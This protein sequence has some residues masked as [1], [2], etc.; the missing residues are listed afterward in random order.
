MP[1]RT[2]LVR[3][4]VIVASSLLPLAFPAS[5]SLADG[6]CVGNRRVVGYYPSWGVYARNYHPADIPA[7]KV[8][9]INYAFAV[10]GPDLL[11]TFGDRF[12][13]IERSYPGDP[14]GQPFYGAF[15]QLNNIVKPAHPHLKTLISVGGGSGGGDFSAAARTPQ[16]RQAFAHSC[17]I[18][19]QQYRFDGIDIDWEFPGPDDRH[20]YTLLLQELR[21]QLG[22]TYLLT[23]AAPPDADR[24]ANFEPAALSQYTDW[25][26]V[27]CYNF[28]GP[29]DLMHSPTGHQAGFDANPLSPGNPQYNTHW[30]M[31]AWLAASVPPAKLLIG[32][33]FFG[34]A[35]GGVPAT[36]DGL[37][38]LGTF[39]PR[40]TW[41]SPNNPSGVN[42]Y[43]DILRLLNAPDSHYLRH[44]D[45][46][47]KAP[48]A[49]SPADQSGHFISF[50]DPQ[51]IAFKTAYVR[52]RALAG[53]M[54][55]EI[56][57]DSTQSLLNAIDRGLLTCAIDFNCDGA[58]TV[59]D[60]L[61]YLALFAA[62]DPRAD[63]NGDESVNVADFLAF[64]AA[65]A[66]G[67]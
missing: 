21:Q 3:S 8:T 57:A 49:Y 39:V 13:D 43:S 23:I 2:T 10:V 22:A 18:F 61:T 4:F 66:A 37:F 7:D 15:N 50:D 29:W 58:A 62:A 59:A 32:L 11:I 53:I 65:F 46:V 9:H 45:A 41:D 34:R 48:W 36:N 28:F 64:L 55:W 1:A 31:D 42:D 40:G 25:I 56:S 12:A 14:P 19:M 6:P 51:S 67:C 60:F 16:S 44:W 38:Q 35:W 33:P 47:A 24:M 52:Q 27:M 20:N 63:F 17:V 26:G 54:F 30:A 5:P